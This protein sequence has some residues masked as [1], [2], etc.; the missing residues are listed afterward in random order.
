M[1][2][3]VY[4][5]VYNN[6]SVKHFCPMEEGRSVSAGT[7]RLTRTAVI[8]EFGGCCC[9]RRVVR[10]R[11]KSGI[12]TVTEAVSAHRSARRTLRQTGLTGQ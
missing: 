9:G 2:V 12:K 7:G 6:T 3:I 11:G 1:T 5:V 8:E 4:S 10:D